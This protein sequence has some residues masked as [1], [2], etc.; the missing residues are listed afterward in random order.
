MMDVS[1]LVLFSRKTSI[2]LFA[3]ALLLI[4]CSTPIEE[5]VGHT[6]IAKWQ[7]AK[8]SAV[9]L[10][11]DDGII[12][13][14]TVARPILNS[15]G[16]K[17]TF[18]IITGK[19]EGS[20]EGKFIGRPR[21]EIIEESRL[22]KT[23][24]DNFFER[25]SLIGF[26]G[27]TEAIDYHTRAGSLFES[28]KITEAYALIDKGY[29]LLRK[30]RLKNTDAVVFHN[31]AVDT[32]SWADYKS[33]AAEGHEIA[34]H[35]VTHPRLAVLDEA[36]L[37][38]EL[39]QSKADIQ[40]FLGEK[41]TFSAECPF[42]TENERVMKYAH[43]AYS[44]LRNRMPET[45]L[46]ELNRSS[47]RRPDESEKEYVQWQRGP[48]SNHSMQLMKSWVDTCIANDNIWLV[49]VF[50]GVDGIGWEPKT[51][52]ELEEYFSYMKENEANLWIA[53]FAEVTKYIRERK[54]TKL[55]SELVNNSIEVHFS[56]TLDPVV[57]NVPLTL[58]TYVPK[59][60]EAAQLTK[61]NKQENE[62]LL[63]QKDSLGSYVYYSFSPRRNETLVIE[64]M[65][66]RL[67]R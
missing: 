33:Y 37:R 31:N 39:E 53:P 43:K 28:G 65:D 12:K 48:L 66:I 55:S 3:L 35:S 41:Y 36:N 8:Q 61:K 22:I 6:R 40:N 47:E 25:A 17:G 38:Y 11:F 18:Y 4:T 49:L 24:A 7:G 32:T 14:M 5:N 20:A 2:Y 10:T 57:Y 21:K 34:S 52:A 19:V 67:V 44:A 64:Q 54:T 59:A 51:K 58:K 30:G 46:D 13:Q 27:T 9:S 50:H 23:N 56:S 60:W 45:Y 26:T 15:M 16:L 62:K 42:G 63:V 29:K 1:H